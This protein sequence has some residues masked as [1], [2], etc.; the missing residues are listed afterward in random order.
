MTMRSGAASLAPSAVPDPQP[1]PEAAPAFSNVP[2]W[3]K[4]MNGGS[5]GDSLITMVSSSL[6]LSMQWV[7]QTGLTG[8]LSFDSFNR[9]RQSS[10]ISLCCLARTPRR[11]SMRDLATFSWA[12]MASPRASSPKAV[13][14]VNAMSLG[15]PRIG[16]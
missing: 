10:R 12:L 9:C 7:S 6:M 16:T 8:S 15:K 14:Q 1:S 4:S 13:V 2:G 5:S 3:L 11:V